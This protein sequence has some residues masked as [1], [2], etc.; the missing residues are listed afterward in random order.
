M[1]ELTKERF[2]TVSEVAD[3]LNVS[4]QAIR[5][6]VKKLFPEALKNGLTTYLDEV[7]V[8]AIKLQIQ[9]GGNR[10]LKDNFEL[11]NVKTS[12]EKKLIVRQAI[13]LL[14]EEISELRLEN[15]KANTQIKMLVHDF[16]KTYTTTEIAKELNMKSAQQLNNTLAEMKVQYRQNGT[17]V[18]FSNYSDKGY[19]S[20]KETV[21]DTGKIVY[22]RL[23][24][25]L[26]RQF[27]LNL[28]QE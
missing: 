27:L 1:N 26:G 18:L 6:A 16:N 10:Y 22:D 14:E 9:S 12:L 19:T 2:M 28:I 3:A 25:G 13:D 8:T 15:E 17:W 5:D 21:L 20:I 11:K 7:Q 23:W 24:T 4:G